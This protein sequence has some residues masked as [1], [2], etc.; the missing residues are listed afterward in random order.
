MPCGGLPL[1]YVASIQRS[2]SKTTSTNKNITYSSQYK[3]YEWKPAIGPHCIVNMPSRLAQLACRL[4]NQRTYNQSVIFYLFQKMIRMRYREHRFISVSSSIWCQFQEFL[5]T[6]GLQNFTY[7]VHIRR[8][9]IK[10]SQN[11]IRIAKF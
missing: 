5:G 8:L 7:L 4:H 6:F 2:T 11:S 9:Q 10:N 1:G 3:E